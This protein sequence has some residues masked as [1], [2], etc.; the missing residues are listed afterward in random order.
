M[1]EHFLPKTNMSPPENR[2]FAPKG[3]PSSETTINFQRGRGRANDGISQ[4][5]EARFD[6][7]YPNLDNMC[8]LKMDGEMVEISFLLPPH[9]LFG[10]N[11][12][13][14][15][16]T[17]SILTSPCWREIF[18]CASRFLS[19]RC[20]FVA[21]PGYGVRCH[22]KTLTEI[23]KEQKFTGNSTWRHD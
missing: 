1:E 10:G 3:K 11:S 9:P 12:A 14:I 5:L 13:D 23:S 15:P 20:R 18:P 22:Q 16:R 6:S 4:C 21:L 8:C 17:E 19:Y 7:I 2:P